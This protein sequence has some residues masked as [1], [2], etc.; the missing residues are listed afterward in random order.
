MAVD[1]DVRVVQI[2]FYLWRMYDIFYSGLVTRT[3]IATR[4]FF[5]ILRWL[6]WGFFYTM[7]GEKFYATSF[8]LRGDTNAWEFPTLASWRARLYH[9]DF[10][11]LYR[12]V[13]MAGDFLFYGGW[14]ER[15]RHGEFSILSTWTYASC[16]FSTLWRYTR[17]RI[18]RIS[19]SMLVDAHED[20]I[21]RIFLFCH[22][23]HGDLLFVSYFLFYS[24]SRDICVMTISLYLLTWQTTYV[25]WNFLFC[26][27]HRRIRSHSGRIFFFYSTRERF[28][29]PRRPTWTHASRR[30]S[31]LYTI[32][33]FPRVYYTHDR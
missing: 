6:S 31:T 14:R 26:D 23:N 9:E 20:C 1:V 7:T 25:S 4:A 3:R 17:D 27:I 18:M 30:F 2:F 19:Y 21:T 29:I 8:L 32:Y 16:K 15:T 33:D 24:E 13:I 22:D 12:A 28:P 5:Y 10:S 11:V